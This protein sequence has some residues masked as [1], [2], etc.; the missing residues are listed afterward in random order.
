MV[1][2]NAITI[3]IPRI[4]SLTLVIPQIQPIDVELPRGAGYSTPYT[5]DYVVTPLAWEETVLPTYGKLMTDDVTVL[6]IPY[7]RT[8][9]PQGGDTIFIGYQEAENG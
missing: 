6:E 1:T 4:E 9:N 2:L 5:G 8:S 3:E 7:Y